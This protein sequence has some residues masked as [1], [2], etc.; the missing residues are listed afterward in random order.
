MISVNN[1]TRDGI[2]SVNTVASIPQTHVV[3]AI[4]KKPSPPSVLDECAAVHHSWYSGDPRGSRI[5][6]RKVQAG[7]EVWGRRS[8]K[9]AAI[10][11]AQ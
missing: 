8:H 10:N 4:R 5:L 3:P 11:E 6:I 9:D 7:D 1:L 2:A